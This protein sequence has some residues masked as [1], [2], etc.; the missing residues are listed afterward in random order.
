MTVHTATEAPSRPGVAASVVDATKVYGTGA[1]QVRAL[2]QVT[3]DFAT[4][5]FTAVMGPSGSGR[6][7]LPQCLAGLD[8]LTSGSAFVGGTDLGRLDDKRL[9]LLRRDRIG[10]VFQA[11]NL[12][13]TLTA[14]ANVTLPRAADG[15]P[16]RRLR[17]PAV[18]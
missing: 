4:G 12:V 17:L 7:T 14:L 18:P 2:D 10:F 3:L 1:T 8:A 15:A 16:R 11:Y 6:S 13:P 9:T 5:Q